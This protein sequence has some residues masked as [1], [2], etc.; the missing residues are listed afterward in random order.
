MKNLREE[1]MT[2]VTKNIKGAID[3]SDIDTTD[4]INVDSISATINILIGEE[5]AAIKSYNTFLKNIKGVIDSEIY[6]AIKDEIDEIIK[7]E[8]DHI[9]KLTVVQQQLKKA[10]VNEVKNESYHT[11][12]EAEENDNV[13]IQI[14]MNTWDNYNTNGGYAENINGGWMDPTEALEWAEKEINN[15]NEP[16]IND[17]DSN[18]KIPFEISEDGDVIETIKNIIKFSDFDIHTKKL[19]GAIMEA[20]SSYTF[21]EAISK[22]DSGDYVFYEDVYTDYDLGKADVDNSGSILDA[23]GEDNVKTYINEN[24]IYDSWESD[25]RYEYADENEIDIDSIDDEDFEE[26]AWN[27]INDSIDEAIVDDDEDFLNTWFDYEEYG[28]NLSFDF[29]ITEYGAIDLY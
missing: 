22:S 15:G 13:N 3:K 23:V 14:Y 9:E 11:I 25:L 19:I 2:A 20:D 21:E 24:D 28:R 12:T 6:D 18:I 8:Q 26:Y 4:K 5:N 7:D 10:K 29:V 1:D 27:I 17:V 16:F